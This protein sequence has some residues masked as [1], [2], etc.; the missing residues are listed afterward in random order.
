MQVRRLLVILPLACVASY[1]QNITGSILGQVAD[2]SGSAIPSAAVSLR[3]VDTGA[4]AQTNTDSL[5]SY[6]VPN[7]LAG[8]YEITVR[9]P[10]FQTLTVRGL[11]LLSAQTLR[12][13][14]KLEVGAVQQSVEVAGQASLIRTD[15]QTIGSSLGSRQV[16][17]L[18]LA[19]RSIDSLLAMAPGV[20]TT[21]ANPRISGSS[22]W[23]GTNFTLNGISVNDSAN[24]RASGTSGVTN[25]GEVNLPAPD[26]LQE[27]KIESG[28]QSA[29]Y[30]NVAS[31]MMVI[32]Q[33]TN[34]FHGLAYEFLQNTDLN[35]NTLLLN[36]TGQPRA[37]SH[38][39]QF[40]GDLGGPILKNR[41]FVYGAYRGVRNLFPRTVS[42]SL[43]SMAM[44]N[45]DFSALCSDFS[46]GV[47]A[48]GTQL[49]NPFTGAAFAGNQIPGSLIAPQ[50]KTLM[51][52]L[53]A[54]TN[55]ISAALPGGSPNYIAPVPNNAGVNGVDFRLDG[56]ISATDSV[57]GIFH[58]SRGAP[59]ILASGNT[60]ANYGNSADDG[61][62][63]FA[64]SAT[65]TH[66]FGPAMIN[67][68][69]AAWVVHS[70]NHNGQNSSFNPATLFPQLPIVDNGGLPQMT[71]TGYNGMFTDYGKGYPYPEYDIEL[72]D[73]FTKVHGRHTFKFGVDES[74][75]KNYTRQGGQA[76]TGVT[77][78]PLGGFTF[79]G[80]WTANKGWPGQ[81]TS[82]GNAFA[83]FL[84]G[85]PA[86]T[87]FAGPLTDF[88]LAGRDWE[89]YGQ[90]T[91]Q[92]TPKL[93]L[94]Y[95]LRYVYQTPWIVRDDRAT[96]LDLKNNKL[97]IPEDS[98][99]LTPPRLAI[100]SLL[101][102]YPY[103]TTQQAGW[104]K[105]Y[106]IPDK[107]NF[108]PRFGFAYR[109]F[110][111]SKT[112]VRGGWG[113]YY[114][115]IRSNAGAYPN[116]F[117]PPWRTGSTWSSALPGKPTAPFL[118]DL[119]FQNPFPASGQSGAAPNPLLY[120]IERDNVNPVTQQWNLTVEQQIGNQ[121]AARA[122]YVGAQTRHV[123]YTREDINRPNV[124]QPNVPLQAQRI[125]QPWGEIDDT[126]TSGRVFMNQLQLELNKRFSSGFLFQAEYSFTASRD[127]AS[128]T[129]GAQNPNNEMA[130]YGNT[131]SVPRQ[132]L[133][134]NYLY[135]LPVGRGRKV[136]LSNKLVDAV[137]GG[138]S[139]SGITAYRTG[140]P[141]SV[142][143]TVPS[144]VIGWWGGRADAV[145]GGSIYSGK[146]SSHDVIGG[147]QW[148]N[149]GAF[150]PPQP[151]Q[152]G[153]AERN[154]VYGPGSAN[155]DI[156]AQKIFAITEQRR[157]QVRADFLDAFNHFN[158]GTPSST[159]AD[160]RDGGSPNA[161]AGKIFSGS[162][163]RIVQLGLK[164]V[165]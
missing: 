93:T 138:W 36:A 109:P 107:N 20:E 97:A 123:F 106:L 48:K 146:S 87:N 158:L 118:P 60:P 122:S 164:Y 133:V 121:W 151:W 29:E 114:D 82:A 132:A 33:G 149:P 71:M 39:N 104:P 157:L 75:Y 25:F 4:T 137:L 126:K 9:R 1:G 117:D 148:F 53:P 26:S 160:T 37:P 16:A 113:V 50:A 101:S 62:T 92:V 139:I 131:D 7:L 134:F 11:Q 99:T 141:F 28:N 112:V 159:I 144:S 105:S 66:I 161:S 51:P 21:G 24:S 42:L 127:N 69:R 5:G 98:A 140:A 32:K 119:T 125:Y 130:D 34:K 18:P 84:L 135:D 2:P 45:G 80:Q 89:F 72:V 63:D 85:L 145:A 61:Y 73:N 59:W 81:P 116:E 129:G 57:N 155:W 3:N 49:Y 108:A 56:Q 77:I 58:W 103:E 27:F 64:I 14:M 95:G 41:L 124:Q 47:C 30:R 102:A 156:G 43:P 35:A 154:S 94:N 128:T 90:D 23:G 143:F 136:D 12:Q 111:G 55:L 88:Q 96:Y 150:A 38:V 67:E 165:F 40:G 17:D 100:P 70:P 52:Y 78:T 147:V 46:G 91:F 13:D 153:N 8:T 110:A 79:N 115:F 162:G 6:S 163:N 74:G 15:S 120:M 83:D 152:W 86:T 54:P 19:G 31:V 65:E 22:Y 76:L 142:N 68:F 10:G 44:R